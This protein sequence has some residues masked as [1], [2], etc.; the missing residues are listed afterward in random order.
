VTTGYDAIVIGAR[1]A[2]SPT[3]MLLARRGYRV[4]MVDRATFPSDTLSTHFLHPPGVAALAR[5]G[6]L[7][8]L[9]A[10][11]CP[12]IQT[13]SFDFGPLTIAGSPRAVEGVDQA[14]C[15]RR[16]VI[17]SILVEAAA[18]AGVEVRQGFSVDEI[19]VED[20]TVVGVRGKEA[21]GRAVTE[22]ARIVIGAD[23]RNSSVARAV[24][25][26]E[27]NPKPAIGPAIYSYWSG[28]G[29]LGFEVAVTDT[30]GMALFPTHD[31][32]TLVIVGMADDDFK[33]ARADVEGSVLRFLDLVPGMGE[34][35]RSGK[36]EERFRT[37]SDLAGWF[38]TPYGPGWAL[39]G[40]AGYLLHPITAQGMTNA[41]LDAERLADA[42]DAAFAERS[43]YDDAMA[44]YQ[45][46]RD[47]Y[48]MPMYEMTFELASFEPPPPE[49]QQL[50]GAIAS[51]QGAMDDFVSVQAG[52]LPIPEFFH[53]DNVGR[54][55]AGAPA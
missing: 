36:R 47:E 21:G 32:L 6:L 20:G 41:F 25:P 4:L 40:D 12:P 45:R 48:A 53:P 37:A 34:R 27:Y 30:F 17:D 19:L 31:D 50:L 43:P 23:G 22:R 1:C 26:E 52:T 18:A 44:A 8:A 5:W 54:I 2:G 3:A 14:F 38:R 42:V 28:V 51:D 9:A 24:Q 39:V 16:Q 35:V 15:P 11:N 7:D 13:Y 29:S 10:S 49:A 33:A 46:A 55:L